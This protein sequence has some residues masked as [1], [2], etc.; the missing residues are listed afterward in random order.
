MIYRN[1]LLI[2]MSLMKSFPIIGSSPYHCEGQAFN[3]LWTIWW[4]HW[5]NIRK[6]FLN[7]LPLNCIELY[8]IISILK[9]NIQCC[10]CKGWHT[11]F[12]GEFTVFLNILV[13]YWP[14]WHCNQPVV[15]YS[16]NKNYYQIT[17]HYPLNQSSCLVTNKY[18]L[19]G[20]L[21]VLITHIN[22]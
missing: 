3:L 7:K 10:L 16:M 11:G 5:G 19:L 2:M 22:L 12:M 21:L 8:I 1:F 14:L 20:C 6:Y 9:N 18:L 15:W 17:V 4:Q 13:W